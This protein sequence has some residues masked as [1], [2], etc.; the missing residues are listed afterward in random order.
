MKRLIP[1]AGN[2]AGDG[3]ANQTAAILKRP[4]PNAGNATTNGDAG[5]ASTI[6]KRIVSDAGNTVRYNEKGSGFAQWVLD[7]GGLSF[8][9]QDTI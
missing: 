1:N 2:A 7:E 6:L 3:Y 8:I 9:I 4:V 5:Q